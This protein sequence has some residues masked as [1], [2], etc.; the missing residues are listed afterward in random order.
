MHPISGFPTR[1][2]RFHRRSSRGDN[3]AARAQRRAPN[4]RM[5]FYQR[6]MPFRVLPPQNGRL[7]V[8]LGQKGRCRLAEMLMSAGPI[9][10]AALNFQKGE[11][12]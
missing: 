9:G 6:L 3:G 5:R 1:D 11:L 8:R 7:I 10:A 12:V 4:V 2:P